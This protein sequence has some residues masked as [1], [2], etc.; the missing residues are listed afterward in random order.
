MTYSSS[1]ILPNIFSNLTIQE[2]NN[3]LEN[4]KKLIIGKIAK[5]VSENKEETFLSN[6]E[7]SIVFNLNN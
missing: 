2:F 3:E 4:H 6:E 1:N 5:I 7:L